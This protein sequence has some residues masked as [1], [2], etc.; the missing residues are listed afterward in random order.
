MIF[1]QSCTKKNTGNAEHHRNRL[2]TISD[3]IV[4]TVLS[5]RVTTQNKLLMFVNF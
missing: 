5:N 2:S 3:K 1:K 4:E